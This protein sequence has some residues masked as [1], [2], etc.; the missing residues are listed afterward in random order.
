MPVECTL[1]PAGARERN[2]LS[3]IV[4]RFVIIAR[5]ER[6]MESTVEINKGHD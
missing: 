6:E 3:V 5:G 2:G 4:S 1:V